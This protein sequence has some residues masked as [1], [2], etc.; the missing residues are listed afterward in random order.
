MEKNKDT[1]I[2]NAPNGKIIIPKVQLTI[3]AIIL[4]GYPVLSTVMNYF[5]PPDEVEIDSRI[6]QVY[7]PALIFQAIVFSCL[8]IAVLKAPL[9][10]NGQYW[11]PRENLSSI[12]IKRSD[13]N[14]LNLAIGVIFMFAAIIIL[15]MLSNI[16]G[17]YGFFQSEDITYLLPRTP[18]ERIVWIMLSLSAGV[19]EELSFRGFVLTRMEILTGSVWPGVILSSFSFGIGHL[20][21]GWAGVVI[22]GV[23]GLMFSLLFIARGSLIPCIVAHILQD[24]LAAFAV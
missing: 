17:Y 1:E 15:N 24:L 16:I 4:I 23:Y 2:S 7:L 11:S 8:M 21:Q 12:G 20:Y 14:W 13:F 5:S 19:A 3:L 22:I 10:Q 9:K 18:F 6:L